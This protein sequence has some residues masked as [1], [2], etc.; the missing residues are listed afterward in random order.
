MG[1]VRGA[2][3]SSE[4]VPSLLFPCKSANLGP[5]AELG[6]P[7][8]WAVGP[9]GAFPPETHPAFAALRHP[10]PKGICAAGRSRRAPAPSATTRTQPQPETPRSFLE[11]P[12]HPGALGSPVSQ[13]GR[14]GGTPR[15][16]C[17]G[18][19]QLH[20]LRLVQPAEEPRQPAGAPRAQSWSSQGGSDGHRALRWLLPG[21]TLAQEAPCCAHQ[22]LALCWGGKTHLRPGESFCIHPA[23]GRG[24]LGSPRREASPPPMTVGAGQKSSSCSAT[25]QMGP[26]RAAK[27]TA[28]VRYPQTQQLRLLS[29][30]KNRSHP[31][32]PT[33]PQPCPRTSTCRGTSPAGH[34]TAPRAP[35]HAYSFARPGLEAVEG[36]RALPMG[37]YK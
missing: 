21:R 27:H 22:V 36:K 10:Q 3:S 14:C 11:A 9:G 5:R 12:S 31:R 20:R 24:C 29:C 6:H 23:P 8:G 34:G 15:L 26:L 35:T 16:L 30:T 4:P 18:R 32:N 7:C 33:T 19:W 25:P 28:E 2:S 17:A 1:E 37:R 13:K